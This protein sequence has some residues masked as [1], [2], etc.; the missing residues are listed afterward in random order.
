MEKEGKREGV[1][2]ERV[3]REERQTCECV[4]WNI[5]FKMDFILHTHT[6]DSPGPCMPLHSTPALRSHTVY[7]S[8]VSPHAQILFRSVIYEYCNTG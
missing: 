1:E 4:M 5:S 2:G 8:P 7:P 6:A 3:L